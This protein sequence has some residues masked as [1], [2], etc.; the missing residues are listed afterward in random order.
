MAAA[1]SRRLHASSSGERD[2]LRRSERLGAELGAPERSSA[3]AAC[4]RRDTGKLERVRER[5]APVREGG[6]NDALQ[7]AY[8]GAPAAAGARSASERRVDI[9]LRAEAARATG[10]KPIA[11]QVSW[12]STDTAP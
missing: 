1:G 2:E 5:L 8:S 9:R 3:A 7:A 6:L 4:S 10:W 12:T 11:S